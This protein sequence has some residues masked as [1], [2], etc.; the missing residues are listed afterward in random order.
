[1]AQL[2]ICGPGESLEML[3]DEV[4]LRVRVFV[5]VPQG[6]G[7]LRAG[8]SDCQSIQRLDIDDV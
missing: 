3:S 1:M 8:L 6:A 4:C 7:F 5:R 2:S